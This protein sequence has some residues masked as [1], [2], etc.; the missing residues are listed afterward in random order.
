MCYFALTPECLRAN[1]FFLFDLETFQ[2]VSYVIIKILGTAFA[3][4]HDGPEK[5]VFDYDHDIIF[6]MFV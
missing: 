5:L 3:D 4:T 6:A 2:Y 1:Q